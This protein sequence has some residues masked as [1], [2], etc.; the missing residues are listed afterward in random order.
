MSRN[1]LRSNIFVLSRLPEQGHVKLSLA[2]LTQLHEKQWEK[3][4]KHNSEPLMDNLHKMIK[5]TLKIFAANT[6][7]FL[8]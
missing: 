7:R 4:I 6:A 8:T 3:Q 5:L 1:A 2:K